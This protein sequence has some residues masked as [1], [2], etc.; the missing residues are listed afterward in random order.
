MDEKLKPCPFCGNE[1]PEFVKPTSFNGGRDSVVC[2]CG[3]SVLR[4]GPEGCRMVL[5]D[6]GGYIATYE[7]I[8]A[9]NRR[10]YEC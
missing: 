6:N 7:A 4:R 1:T 3:A 9:W 10:V 5:H 2:D 8:K